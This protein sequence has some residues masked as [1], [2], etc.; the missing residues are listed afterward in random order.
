MKK[1]MKKMKNLKSTEKLK[2]LRG[3]AHS[4]CNL[5]Y[6]VPK[7]IPIVIHNAGYDTHFIINQ[8]A[9]EFKSKFDC[10]GKN[11]EKYI[12]FSV[13][14]KKNVT[15]VKQLHTSLS[16]VLDL[17]QIRYQILLITYLKLTKKNG[18]HALMEK[19]INKNVI[20]L[21]MKIVILRFKC[22]KCDRIWL[23]PS[24]SSIL[25]IACL[26]STKKN[27]KHAWEEKILN[28]SVILWGLKIIN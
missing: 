1:K 26:K 24:L 28:Q 13:P 4:D 18:N 12:T 23:K 16:I 2:K 7:N 21:D 8:S 6:K 5:K 11:M 10:I 17:C 15:I 25:L 27:A 20:L 22:K 3:A 9:E 14:F 19:L